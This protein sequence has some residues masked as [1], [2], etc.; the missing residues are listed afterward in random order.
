MDKQEIEARRSFIGASE[1]PKL[2]GIGSPWSSSP[3]SGPDC[4]GEPVNDDE[5]DD[6]EKEDDE[7]ETPEEEIRSREPAR[8][9]DREVGGRQALQDLGGVEDHQNA[10]GPRVAPWSNPDFAISPRDFWAPRRRL[11]EVKSSI[12]RVGWGREGTTRFPRAFCCRP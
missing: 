3:T 9:A 8:G 2:L 10:A 1:V 5:E 12:V 6:E 11:L 4:V 7:S